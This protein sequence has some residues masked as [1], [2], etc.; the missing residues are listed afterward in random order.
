M[1]KYLFPLI[2]IVLLC[3]LLI[4]GSCGTSQVSLLPDFGNP[5]VIDE[6]V[7]FPDFP[8]AVPS[9]Y[10]SNA[11]PLVLAS[12]T[13]ILKMELKPYDKISY[14]V[15]FNGTAVNGNSVFTYDMNLETLENGIYEIRVLAYDNFTTVKRGQSRFSLW[16]RLSSGNSAPYK[17]YSPFP[18]NGSTDVPTDVKLSW[19]GFD[20]DFDELYY[21]IWFAT[22]T[23]DMVKIGDL[24]TAT[25]VSAP[26][27]FGN[28]SYNWQVNTY[29]MFEDA[30]RSL[31]VG[32]IWN[33]STV[34]TGISTSSDRRIMPGDLE[35]LGAFLTPEPEI[36]FEDTHM[37]EYGGMAMAYYPNGDAGGIDDD[38]PGSLFGAGYDVLHLVSEISIPVP[39]ISAAKNPDELNTAETIQGFSNLKIGLFDGIVEMPRMGM[40]YLPAQ[41][42][43]ASEKLYLCWG[44]HMQDDAGVDRI[45]SHMWCETVLDS[46]DAH[47]AWW[48]GNYNLYSIN[49]YL[50][51][52]PSEWSESNTPGMRL[53]TGRYRDG[54]WSGFGPT[55]VAIGPWLDGNPPANGSVLSDVPLIR[56]SD[57]Y[58]GEPS[59]SYQ[60]DGYAHSDEWSGGA[61]LTSG[62]KSAVIFVGTKGIGDTWYGNQDGPCL[63]CDNR[64]WWSE[65][66]RGQIIFYDAEE[67][68]MV[69]RGEKQPYE[70]QPYAVMEI[71]EILYN[72][73]SEQEWFH[74]GACSYDRNNRLLYVFEP[75]RAEGE[76]TLIHVWEISE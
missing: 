56:Y 2:L 13:K 53:A 17:A 34:E 39:V 69:A 46:P 9:R 27:L 72:V 20:S 76:R 45:P 12:D 41:G 52:I 38:Y 66:F 64:G 4:S 43:Q 19:I 49:D 5:D 57:N 59:P 15:E 31:T 32:D 24:T 28:C 1:F 7:L 21:D 54:G 30:Q 50:F 22:D 65:E 63:S 37:W 62:E 55:L 3:L 74:L 47:G 70:P 35:Y 16:I 51:E 73:K 42:S 58:E 68:A 61:W 25:E 26:Y 48:V 11:A 6:T 60:M 71:D 14:A 40:E 23:Y 8:Q 67:I 29:D 75:G 33:F 36:G 44:A 18:A 10:T